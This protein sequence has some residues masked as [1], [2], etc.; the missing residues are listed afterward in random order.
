MPVPHNPPTAIRDRTIGVTGEILRHLGLD[1][2]REQGTRA[3][4]A[5][6][7]FREYRSLAR[8]VFWTD[9]SVHD[10]VLVDVK[11]YPNVT[12]FIVRKANARLFKRLLY[13]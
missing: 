9:I 4:H 6:I 3:L 11:A 12:R 5:V 2:L 8:R 7:N 10:S 13:F 1:C